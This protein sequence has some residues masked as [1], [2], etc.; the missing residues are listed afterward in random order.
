MLSLWRTHEQNTDI[1]RS[2]RDFCSSVARFSI[3]NSGKVDPKE[4]PNFMQDLSDVLCR[5][6]DNDMHNKTDFFFDMDK[7]SDIN[8]EDYDVIKR[9]KA[10]QLNGIL[11]KKQEKDVAE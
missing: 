3:I 1:E 6:N 7:I 9:R 5:I 4:K 8:P 10:R 11:E 2:K